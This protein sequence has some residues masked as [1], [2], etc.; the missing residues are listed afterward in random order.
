MAGVNSRF[1][2]SIKSTFNRVVMQMPRS[3]AVEVIWC[4]Y[5]KT[6]ILFFSDSVNSGTILIHLRGS[7]NALPLLT[8]I[9]E[10]NS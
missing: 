8:S 5:T 2:V 1:E 10:N 6:T 3:V 4:V 9:S 7:V